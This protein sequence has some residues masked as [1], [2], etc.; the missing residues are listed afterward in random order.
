LPQG[1]LTPKR[2]GEDQT[3]EPI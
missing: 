3:S 1:K 2:K